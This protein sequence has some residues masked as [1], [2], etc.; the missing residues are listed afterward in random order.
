MGP[1]KP[2]GYI[3]DH[4]TWSEEKLKSRAKA[5][6]FFAF[7]E[8]VRRP[9][10]VGG[11]TL[12]PGASFILVILRAVPFSGRFHIQLVCELQHRQSRKLRTI[13]STPE[14]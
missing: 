8:L 11:I 1:A 2:Y 4:Y 10:V 13:L 3:G 6:T 12:I 7:H 5:Y 9:S 14:V